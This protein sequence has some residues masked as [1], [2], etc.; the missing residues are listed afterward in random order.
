M[1]WALIFQ[2]PENNY[3]LFERIVDS[4]VRAVE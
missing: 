4:F 2:P 3:V 1:L